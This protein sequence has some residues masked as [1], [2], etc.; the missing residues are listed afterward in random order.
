MKTNPTPLLQSPLWETFEQHLGRQTFRVETDSFSYFGYVQTTRLGSYLYL[1][2]GPL[3]TPSGS[4]SPDDA[5]KSALASLNS[6]CREHNFLFARLEPQTY[7]PP[8]TLSSLGLK[9][10]LDLNPA[11]TW[12][13]DLS[14][15]ETE[16]KSRL[17]SRLLRYYRA[18]GKNGLSIETSHDPADAHYLLDLQKSLARTKNIQ[19]F[20]LDYYKHQL[21]EPFSTLY[22]V[23]QSS[24]VL[25]AGLVFD[26]A[27]TRYNLQGAQSSTGKHLHATGILTLQLIFDAAAKG[28]TTFDFWGIAPADASPDHPW[29]GFTAFKKTFAGTERAYSGT[30]DLPTSSR[31]PLYSL[32]RSLN[33]KLRKRF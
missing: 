30:Y 15:S 24:E 16:L 10:S 3:L 17:P 9:K 12:L 23:K 13:L 1:P 11:E 8:E 26:D 32:L 14:G 28:L 19:T 25:A 22:L 2:Y 4:V 7:F 31:Y 18:R 21:S 33:R 5:L 27:T 20:D 29:A 6:L